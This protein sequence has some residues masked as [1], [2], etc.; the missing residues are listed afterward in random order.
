M[1]AVGG[2]VSELLDVFYFILMYI[3]DMCDIYE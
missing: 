3:N 1:G 2:D